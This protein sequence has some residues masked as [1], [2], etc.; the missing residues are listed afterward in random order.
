MKSLNKNTSVLNTEDL[1]KLNSIIT[2]NYSDQPTVKQYRRFKTVDELLQN[3]K[4]SG[5]HK[6]YHSYNNYSNEL[7]KFILS[8][9][10]YTEAKRKL[11]EILEV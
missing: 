4:L 9:S 8:G 10:E 5:I 2:Q 7:S 6:C 3:A 1:K 11:A